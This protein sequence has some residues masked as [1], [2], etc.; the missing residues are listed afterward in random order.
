MTYDFVISEW[1]YK[2][3]TITTSFRAYHFIL[4]VCLQLLSRFS[5]RNEVRGLGTSLAFLMRPRH[6]FFCFA[7]LIAFISGSIFTFNFCQ[8]CSIIKLQKR[9]V[10][11]TRLGHKTT[12]MYPEIAL[13]CLIMRATLGMMA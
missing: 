9:E 6:C 13:E 4:W 5:S 2:F 1:E 3:V 11:S 10:C 8:C 7:N 12:L